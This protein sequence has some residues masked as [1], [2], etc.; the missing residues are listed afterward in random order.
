[1]SVGLNER[2]AMAV[3][4]DGLGSRNTVVSGKPVVAGALPRWFA[5]NPDRFG[6]KKV[7][8][9]GLSPKASTSSSAVDRTSTRGA[10]GKGG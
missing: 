4:G 2:V 8:C 10:T 6:E 9:A 3:H 1:M 7:L 5:W